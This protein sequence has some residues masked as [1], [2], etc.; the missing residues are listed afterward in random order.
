[1]ITNRYQNKHRIASSLFLL[2]SMLV[3]SAAFAEEGEEEA[4]GIPEM[5][6][7]QRSEMGIVTSLVSSRLLTK[8]IIAPG[9]VTV[10]IYRSS[11]VTSRI[12]SQ[13]IKRYAR[14]GDTVKTGQKLL[15]LSSVDMADAQSRLLITDREWQRVKKLGRKVV[16]ERRYIEAQVNRQQAYAKALA[17]GVTKSQITELLKQKDASKATGMFS[18]LSTQNGTVISDQF[19]SGQVVD[20]GQLLMEINDESLLWVETQINPEDVINIKPGT[21]ARINYTEDNWLP[22]KVIQVHRRIDETTRTLPVRIEVDNQQNLIRPGQF[23]KVALQISAGNE[24]IAVPKSSVTLLQGEQVVFM[25]DGEELYPQLVETGGIRNDWIEIKNGLK[26][27]DKV[28][29]QGMFLLKSLLLKS[30]IGDAD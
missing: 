7:D 1:M 9:E 24:V 11:Q 16:S 15:T 17:Y 18:L 4:Q 8:E 28:V 5:T 3:N 14:M 10:N 23:V 26:K 13:I 19:V 20:P 6:A 21:R 25:L 12:R 29:T 30:Q 2:L 22:A 27:D